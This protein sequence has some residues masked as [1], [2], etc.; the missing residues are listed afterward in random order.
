MES[1][2]NH[3]P[4]VTTITKLKAVLCL[5]MLVGCS[6]AGLSLAEIP[7]YPNAVP[8]ESLSQDM[9][10]MTG[11]IVQLTTADSFEQVLEFYLDALAEYQTETISPAMKDGRQTA[12]N[13][14]RRTGAT[15]V[16][17]QEYDGEDTVYITLMRVGT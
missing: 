17:I 11:E 12:I 13:L 16:V 7:R 10:F 14:V 8:G 4:G 6:D 9:G 15:T 2:E 5:L 1:M 3:N